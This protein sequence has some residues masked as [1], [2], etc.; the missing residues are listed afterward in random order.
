MSPQGVASPPVTSTTVTHLGGVPVLLCAPNGP[1]IDSDNAALD[2][3]GEAIAQGAAWV[4]VP[5][6]RLSDDFFVLRTGL[7]GAI[8]QKFVN[9]HQRLAVVGDLSAKL[10]ESNALRS[11]VEESNRGRHLWFVATLQELNDRLQAHGG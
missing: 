11:W 7:A 2:L 6:E 1:L 5:I 4:A 8:T 10:A 3:I 9:Y